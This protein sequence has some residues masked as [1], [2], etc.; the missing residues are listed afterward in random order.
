MRG[1]DD[2]RDEGNVFKVC[3]D[4]CVERVH[5]DMGADSLTRKRSHLA[6]TEVQMRNK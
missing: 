4:E 3:D 5:Q 1:K 2:T 6:L